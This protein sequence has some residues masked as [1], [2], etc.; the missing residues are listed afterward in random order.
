MQIY[1]DLFSKRFKEARRL[2]GKKQREI[3]DVLGVEPSTVS[4]WETGADMPD[5]VRLPDICK[6]LRVPI[7]YFGEDKVSPPVRGR[8]LEKVPEVVEFLSK[9]GSLS[10]ARR[11]LVLAIAF[12]DESRIV[13]GDEADWPPWLSA[14]LS[15]QSK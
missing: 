7:E 5:D 4:R 14:H 10:P 3:A 6:A 8:S 9:F 11:D 15:A 1:R 2:S 12:D 13:A